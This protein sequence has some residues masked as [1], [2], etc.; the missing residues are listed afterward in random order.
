MSQ[1]RFNPPSDKEK[2]AL[3]P[4]DRAVIAQLHA[5]IDRELE[6]PIDQQDEQLI[7]NGIQRIA[8]IKG[9][10]ASFTPEEIDARMT[11]V[12]ARAEAESKERKRRPVRTKTALLAAC[13]VVVLIIGACSVCAVSPTLRAWF[14]QLKNH[15]ERSVVEDTG[16]TYTYAGETKLFGDMEAFLR[17]ENLDLVYPVGL[18]DAIE[19]TG[20]LGFDLEGVRCYNIR[21]NTSDIMMLIQLGNADAFF[22]SEDCEIY[23]TDLGTFYIVHEIV[24][25]YEITTITGII[26]QDLYHFTFPN[27]FDIK[28]IIDT[29]KGNEHET[30][31]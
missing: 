16:I 28:N 9:V 26:G 29:L 2:Q 24:H 4:E 11:A 23:T 15:S 25:E 20:I 12:L 13:L 8:E 21:F 14:E 10:R 1:V 31:N 18:P 3:P 30:G 27:T 6:K 5:E 17:A 22:P 19:I 7:H